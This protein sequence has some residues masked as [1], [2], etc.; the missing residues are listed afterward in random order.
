MF[1]NCGT[2]QLDA[3]PHAHARGSNQRAVG[4]HGER[5]PLRNAHVHVAAIDLDHEL[6]QRVTRLPEKQRKSF[7]QRAIKE[8]WSKR[9]I[10]RQVT[11]EDKT[12]A[13]E[14][15]GGK[16][17]SDLRALSKLPLDPK[18]IATLKG[19]DRSEARRLAKALSQRLEKVSAALK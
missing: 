10:V 4:V 12:P 14:S 1:S 5:L 15:G 2:R 18:G 9:E 17:V 11:G 19:K 8:G 6:W 16:L 13:N 3:Q 7:L